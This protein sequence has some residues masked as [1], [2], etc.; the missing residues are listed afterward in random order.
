[1]TREEARQRIK[2]LLA[3]LKDEDSVE[4]AVFDDKEALE[5]AIEA[6]SIEP[7]EDCIS[8][9]EVINAIDERERVDGNVNA[10]D[11][12]TDICLLSNVQPIRPKGE[13]IRTIH[14]VWICPKCGGHPHKGTGY[15]P[16]DEQM[17]EQW[18]FCN[19]CGA[20]MRGNAHDISVDSIEEERVI[21]KNLFAIASDLLAEVEGYE[22]AIDDIKAE[23]A[24]YKDDKIIH[25]ERNEMIDRV[26]DIID[27]HLADMRGGT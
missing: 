21:K 13:W 10:E 26:L 9:K 20:D 25:L 24:A 2:I 27:K 19:L 5:M 11:I 22:Q 15:S 4:Y 7:C 8:R 17:K 12:R 18:K 16:S 14:D 3:G 1:M 23:I 6:L